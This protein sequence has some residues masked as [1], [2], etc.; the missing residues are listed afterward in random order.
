M[1]NQL[2]PVCFYVFYD[3]LI[4]GICDVDSTENKAGAKCPGEALKNTGLPG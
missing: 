2:F 3:R 1:I 4:Y